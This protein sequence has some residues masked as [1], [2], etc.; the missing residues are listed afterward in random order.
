MFCEDGSS[1]M[2]ASREKRWDAMLDTAE[3]TRQFIQIIIEIIGRKTS[4]EY[5]A[6]TVRN[7]LKKLQPTYPFL[8]HIVIKNT[9][10][11]EI[12][13]CVAVRNELNLINQKQ[14][15]NALKALVKTIMESLGK[16]AGYFFL[17]ETREKIGI[18]YDAALMKTMGVDLTMMQSS[19]I[20]EKK[21][22][23]SLQIEKSDVLR[24][25]LKVLIE[26]VE[27]QTSKTFA[28]RFIS[29]SLDTLRQ[30][31][32]FLTFVTVNDIRYTL[33][34][35]EVVVQQEI[36]S[37]DPLD[38]GRVIESLLHET[39]NV[40]EELGRNSIAGD[41]K[42]HLTMNYL[43]KLEEMGVTIAVYTVGYNAIFKEV[44]KTLID[45]VGKI[46]TESYAIVSVNSF[47]RKIDRTYP[48]LQQVKVEPTK[49]HDEMYQITIANNIE[50][51]SETDARRAIQELLEIIISALGKDAR[52][53]FIQKF[54]DSL[55][56][57]YLSKIEEMGVNFHMIELHQEMLTQR[58]E[59]KPL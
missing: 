46:S 53:E 14:V 50:A 40:L 1:S 22:F 33:G 55:E 48:F 16:I 27:K 13:S 37:V 31:Y 58:E 49:N 15:G 44:I 7:L 19:Y 42:T 8:K 30:H 28:I 18:D 57:K 39:D 3:V 45:V 5:A 36:N 23:D 6:V 47:L 26:V 24:R 56:K 2:S 9:R 25:F 4:E 10:L 51:V 17:K 29:Q 43:V 20:I 59:K 54:K 21:S 35:E 11:L 32:P 34:S 12:E 52:D 41:L 38:L